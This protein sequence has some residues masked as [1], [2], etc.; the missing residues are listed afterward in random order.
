MS[1]LTRFT[2]RCALCLPCSC[3]NEYGRLWFPL[4]NC[5]NRQRRG[6]EDLLSPSL[7][8]GKVGH[9][10]DCGMLGWGQHW[11]GSMELVALPASQLHSILLLVH[12]SHTVTY[13]HKHLYLMLHLAVFWSLCWRNLILLWRWKVASESHW[14]NSS[15]FGG[16]LDQLKGPT[17]LL[18]SSPAFAAQSSHCY[19]SLVNK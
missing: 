1:P 3:V 7:H 2:Q 8:S 10:L 5:F 17:H 16:V 18:V 13:C 11:D 14:D 15:C 9:L 12:T 4:Q 19:L 6:G